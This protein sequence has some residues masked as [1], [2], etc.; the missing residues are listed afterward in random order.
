[1]AASCPW[2]SLVAQTVK[3]LLAIQET[4]V[5]SLAQEDPLKKGMATHSS[6]ITWKIRWTEAPGALVHEVTKS[7]TWQWLTHFSRREMYC[8]LILS[9][10][11]LAVAS[12]QFL[13]LLPHGILNVP[14]KNFSCWSTVDLQCCISFTWTAKWI[15]YIY[16][17]I[18]SFL[19]V[20]FP[21]RPLQNTE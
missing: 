1:M 14:L 11:C 12:L 2:D 16:T 3:N 5:W 21:Y 10:P 18:H 9:A 19:K 13:T 6:I 15:C 8:T 20:L 17:H 4:Q 7:Q